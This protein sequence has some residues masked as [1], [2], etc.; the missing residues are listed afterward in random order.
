[1]GDLEQIRELVERLLNSNANAVEAADN[2][3]R[4]L[5]QQLLAGRPDAGAVRAEK[6]AKLGAA[7]RKSGKIKDFKE[8]DIAI[9]EWLRRWEHEVESLKKLCGI[10]DVLTRE[11]GIGIF[12]DR[13]DFTVVKRLDLAFASRDPVVTWA[14]VTWQALKDILKEEFSP[15]VAQV[16]EVLMQFG[17]GRFK[18]SNE[19]SVAS[20]THDWVEQLPECMTPTTDEECRAFADLMK[21]ALFYY[22]LDDVYIQKDLCDMDG[23]PTFKAYFDQAIISEQKR[24]SFQEIGDSG[25]KLDPGGAA[26]LALLDA[27]Q[28]SQAGGV[29]SVNY[30]NGAYGFKQAGGQYGRG[31]G[32]PG[33]SSG[34][35]GQN[36]GSNFGHPGQTGGSFGGGTGHFGGSSGGTGHFGG[37][38]FGGMSNTSNGGGKSFGGGHSGQ[39][40]GQSSSAGGRGGSRGGRGSR[41]GRTSTGQIIC[42]RCGKTG[43]IAANCPDAAANVVDVEDQSQDED[44]VTQV[45]A[46]EF[47]TVNVKTVSQA[48]GYPTCKPMLTQMKFGDKKVTMECDTAAS[49]NILSQQTYQDIWPRGTGPKLQY[50]KVKVMLA[51]GSKS[52]KQTRSMQYSVVASNGKKVKLHFL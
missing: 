40:P 33:S 32:R 34:K 18:K 52:A 14:D 6:V 24:K 21:R 22:C 19:M 29:A 49:H 37:S 10:P 17:P 4:E 15:K 12:K 42:Y 35:F 47:N 8:G 27:D 31:R 2:R 50:H 16:G 46:A 41:R 39:Q 20:F 13:L 1:M 11:E 9:K 51:D 7:L 25:A 28:M 45:F 5:V 36:G 23:V 44:D 38:S 43:H 3:Q 26:C 30:S 48:A